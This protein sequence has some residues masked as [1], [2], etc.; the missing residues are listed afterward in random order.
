MTNDARKWEMENAKCK[1]E[2]ERAHFPFPISDFLA[3]RL[4]IGLRHWLAKYWH[5]LTLGIQ[6]TLVYRANFLCRAVFNLVP[7]Y[8]IIA[9]W[10]VVYGQGDKSIAGYTVAQMV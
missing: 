10:R 1:M 2:N 8:A 6:N 9:L 4:P 5:V 7:L 3:L